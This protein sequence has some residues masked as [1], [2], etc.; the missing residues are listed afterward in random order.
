MTPRWFLS[1][2]AL[3]APLSAALAGELAGSPE[4]MEEQH[5]VAVESDYSFLRKPADVEH[6]VELG[7]LLEVK[8]TA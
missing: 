2:F 1:L 8:P 3:L 4:S 6:L 7:R 5:E